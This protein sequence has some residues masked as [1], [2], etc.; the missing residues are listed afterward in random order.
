MA[1]DSG[2]MAGAGSLVTGIDEGRGS[3][4][5]S[6]TV[7][8]AF[9]TA[10]LEQT[11]ESYRQIITLTSQIITVLLVANVTL[12]GYAMSQQIAGILL[13]T[14]IFPLGIIATVLINARSAVPLVYTFVNLERKYGRGQADWLG[15]SF[16]SFITSE[17]YVEKLLEIGS[18]PDWQERL[19]RLRKSPLPIVG[20]G[21]GLGRASVALIALAQVVAAFVLWY[22]FDW[23]MF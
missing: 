12:V 20:S 8:I 22:F 19:A 5:E 1:S 23:R 11:S 16:F 9:I 7:A 6:E 17:R 4:A 21:R 2:D 18:L 13:I 3:A 14:P 10:Q 15:K